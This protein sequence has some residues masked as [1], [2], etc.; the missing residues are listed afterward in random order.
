MAQY[1]KKLN[2]TLRFDT[3]TEGDI[4][5]L[6]EEEA[7]H[8]TL[9][10]F[11][12]NAIRFAVAH[13]EEFSRAYEYGNAIDEKRQ[14][15]FEKRHLEIKELSDLLNEDY[16]RNE[17][18]RKTLNR[19][20]EKLY[21]LAESGRLFGL[22]TRAE[23]LALEGLLAVH[24]AKRLQAEIWHGKRPHLTAEEEAELKGDLPERAEEIMVYLTEHY[25]KELSEFQLALTPPVAV[26]MIAGAQPQTQQ[27]Q[28]AQQGTQME[29]QAVQEMENIEPDL[30]DFE[31]AFPGI[32]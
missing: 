22:K 25:S 18:I 14:A 8:K 27:M 24:E 11:I 3:E 32:L 31:N 12:C 28:A 1:E 16:S 5:S 7:A 26:S 9:M 13:S 2:G 19:E 20:L 17:V 4:I 21:I 15:F 6:I 30:D 23:L 29:V 10:A